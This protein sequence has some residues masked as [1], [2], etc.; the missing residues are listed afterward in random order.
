[1][2][3]RLTPDQKVACSNHVVVNY[4]SFKNIFKACTGQMGIT[5]DQNM[6]VRTRRGQIIFLYK[7]NV[8]AHVTWALKNI[9]FSFLKYIYA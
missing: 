4:I 5:Q 8:L 7:K 6:R 9:V 3:A 2:V 1:M